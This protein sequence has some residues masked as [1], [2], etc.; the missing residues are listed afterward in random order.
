MKAEDI[1]PAS[2]LEFR[3]ESGQLLLNGRRMTIFAQDAMGIL[4]EL[5]WDMWEWVRRRDLRPIPG[6]GAAKTI[7]TPSPRTDSGTPNSI[8]SGPG[9]SCT[10]G[11]GSSKFPDCAAVRPRHRRLLHVRYL[12]ALL[13]S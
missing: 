5:W 4:R 10:C 11:K 7:T 1:D 13:R 3:W 12:A 6:S 9:R 8:A 2:W